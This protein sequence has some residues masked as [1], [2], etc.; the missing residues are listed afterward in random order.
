MIY[1]SMA[2]ESDEVIQLLVTMLLFGWF[3]LSN[4][5]YVYVNSATT[6]LDRCTYI[7][8][9]D[10]SVMPR[11]LSTHQ[12][13]FSALLSLQEVEILKRST[14]FLSEDCLDRDNYIATIATTHT[15][16]FL[17]LNS[18]S[19]LWPASRHGEDVVIGV[20][21]SGIWPESSSFKDH[22]MAT[23]DAPTKWKGK[24]DG[25]QDFNSSLCNSKLMGVWYF[26]EGLKSKI[27]PRFNDSARDITGHETHCSSIAAGNYVSSASYFGYALGTA[28]GVAPR[29]R[30]A[31]YKVLWT[32]EHLNNGA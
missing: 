21:D 12:H 24:C 17:S 28:K 7:V 1:R 14:G 10:K 29:A 19:G 11:A 16:E 20:L 25:G 15:S 5:Y 22:G 4:L 26:H 6:T 8:H 9:M 18:A 3:S 30:L 31:V 2:S 27:N 13:C 23:S 32:A